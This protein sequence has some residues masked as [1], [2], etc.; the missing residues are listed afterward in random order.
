M[1]TDY[2]ANIATGYKDLFAQAQP[3]KDTGK[4]VNDSVIEFIQKKSPVSG[5]R[6]GRVKP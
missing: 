1:A 4:I 3:A 2:I 5:Q 6:D